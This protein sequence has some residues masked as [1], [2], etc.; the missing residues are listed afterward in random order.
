MREL[1]AAVDAWALTFAVHA[2]AFGLLALASERFLRRYDSV[3]EL[4][5]RLVL[6]GAL[7][8]ATLQLGLGIEPLGGGW[9]AVPA[10]GAEPSAEAEAFPLGAAAADAPGVDPWPWLEVA[11]LVW[12]AAGALGLVHLAVVYAG[13][14]RRLRPTRTVHA[15]A[16]EATSIAALLRLRR[17]PAIVASDRVPTP[18]ALGVRHP[19]VCIPA[20]ALAELGGEEVRAM[21]AHEMAH[22]RRR[23]PAWILLYAV[24][25]R[26]LFWHPALWL[27]RRRLLDLAETRCDAIA[28]AST[29]E[30]GVALARALLRVA[31]WLVPMPASAAVHGRAMAASCTG[32]ERRVRLLLA[33]PQRSSRAAS[34]VAHAGIVALFAGAPF[35]LPGAVEPDAAAGEPLPASALPAPLSAVVEDVERLRA[36]VAELHDL[37]ARSGLAD[38]QVVAGLLAE[39]DRRIAS[40]T[41]R[42]ST[43][44][45]RLRTDPSLFTHTDRRH[46]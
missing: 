28:G 2:G 19:Q 32:L 26:A 31:E 27:A 21:L 39:I 30:A 23:D 36:E 7:L 43:M 33:A 29:Q 11:T 38:D 22:L 16:D 35:V 8:T 42:C 20:R 10:T 17:V 41:A 4:L 9:P 14:R 3:R 6:I 44:A 25:C 15:L 45:A 12:L 40:L 18:L 24:V 46:P 37:V 1:L 5:W 34:R 13:L